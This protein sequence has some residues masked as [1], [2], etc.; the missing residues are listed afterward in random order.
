MQNNTERETVSLFQLRS[1]KRNSILFLSF[2][3][4][5]VSLRWQRE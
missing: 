4:H 5:F 1:E 2:S 3:E